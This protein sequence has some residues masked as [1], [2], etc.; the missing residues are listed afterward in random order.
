MLHSY[1]RICK[2]QVNC[3]EDYRKWLV[4]MFALLVTKWVKVFCGP[5]WKVVSTSQSVSDPESHG[6]CFDPVQ[7][8]VYVYVCRCI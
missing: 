4:S 7:V 5:M 3:P 6:R 2:L 8:C 1:N